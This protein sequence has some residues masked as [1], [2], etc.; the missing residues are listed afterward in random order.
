MTIDDATRN[1]PEYAQLSQLYDQMG[2]GA[3][4]GRNFG[5]SFRAL[6]LKRSGDAWLDSHIRFI[7]TTMVLQFAAGGLTIVGLLVWLTGFGGGTSGDLVAIVL[8]GVAAGV[9]I[10]SLLRT[11][12]AA[13]AFQNGE[14]V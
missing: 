11:K 8:F 10:W 4:G 7:K 12:K 3:G 1:R 2:F 6:G 5:A 9:G 13:T 14:S